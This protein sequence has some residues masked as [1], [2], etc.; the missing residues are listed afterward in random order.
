[1][2]IVGLMNKHPDCY[3]L[4]VL[5][6][7]SSQQYRHVMV[8][9][10]CEVAAILSPHELPHDAVVKSFPASQWDCT[11]SGDPLSGDH[12]PYL[13]VPIGWPVYVKLTNGVIYGCDVIVSATGVVPNTAAFKVRSSS[14]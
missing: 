3:N 5:Y 4:E 14:T 10:T 8:E 11:S 12:R 6:L 2:E 7:S 1:M 9:Y 13:Y